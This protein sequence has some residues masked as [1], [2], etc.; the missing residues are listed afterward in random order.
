MPR[1]IDADELQVRLE[2]KKADVAKQRHTEGW[3]DCMMRV[4]S[5]VSKATTADVAPVVHGKWQD[6]ARYND[7]ERV[8]ATCSYCKDRGELR[9]TRTE[10]GLWVIDSLC[11]P[12]CGARM[13]V[14]NE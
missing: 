14:E 7:G 13:D 3:N 10:F 4:K 11:C 6:I 5:M 9:T 8:I 12:N 2:R 1:Y